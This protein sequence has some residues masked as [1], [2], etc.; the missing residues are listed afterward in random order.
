MLIKTNSDTFGTLNSLVAPIVNSHYLKY[1]QA[2]ARWSKNE[3]KKIK[4]G[5]KNTE[6]KLF[7]KRKWTVEIYLI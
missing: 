4:R 7:F 6:S 2:V 1:R 3:R 5:A